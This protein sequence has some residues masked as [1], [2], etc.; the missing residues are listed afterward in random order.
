MV[1]CLFEPRMIVR[2]FEK[3]TEIS[4][5]VLFVLVSTLS[6]EI[7]VVK[8]RALEVVCIPPLQRRE[9]ATSR[10]RRINVNTF[11]LMTLAP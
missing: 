9:E 3:L 1:E 8:Y 2:V 6:C 7:L 5:S 10:G 11:T 4:D